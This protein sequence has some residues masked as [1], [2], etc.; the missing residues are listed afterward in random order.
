MRH[1]TGSEIADGIRKALDAF[2][3][4]DDESHK[5]HTIALDTLRRFAG[6]TMTRRQ[7]SAIV[8]AIAEGTGTHFWSSEQYGFNVA[9]SDRVSIY[10]PALGTS[11]D[12]EAWNE[13]QTCTGSA[14]AAR[15]ARRAAFCENDIA[16]LAGHIAAVREAWHDLKS[17]LDACPDGGHLHPASG[18]AEYLTGLEHRRSANDP[19]D[20][21]TGIEIRP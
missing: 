6:Q 21:A 14:A 19:Y 16:I 4:H 15:S 11:I 2:R 12:P 18:V 17:L 9:K 13:S 5:A 1:L 8:R 20:K 3:A 7:T 10:L